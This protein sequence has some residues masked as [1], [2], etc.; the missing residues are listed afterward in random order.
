MARNADGRMARELARSAALRAHAPYSGFK[1]GAVLETDDDR[2]I[3]GCNLES[4]SIGLSLCAERN[5]L[6][7]AVATGVVSCKRLWI[8]TP[9]SIP[10]WPCGACR[11][12]LLRIC[13]DIEVLLLCDGEGGAP[14]RSRLSSLLPGGIR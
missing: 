6:A 13:G 3:P 14:T 10:T 5:A 12:L 2:M 7:R 4:A 8:Y 9:T 11:E 1:V